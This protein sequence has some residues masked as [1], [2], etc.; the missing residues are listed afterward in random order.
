MGSGCTGVCA[1]V[2]VRAWSKGRGGGC[3]RGAGAAH[4]GAGKQRWVLTRPCRCGEQGPLAAAAGISKLKHEVVVIDVDGQG[5]AGFSLQPVG[6]LKPIVRV[7]GVQRRQ[8]RELDVCVRLQRGVIRHVGWANGREGCPA[9]ECGLPRQFP[10]PGDGQPAPSPPS[11]AAWQS[12]AGLAQN[13][14]CRGFIPPCPRRA[15][16]SAAARRTGIGVGRP[17]PSQA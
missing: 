13:A 6:P 17:R 5:V 16:A 7:Q 15:V 10:D 9:A 8:G 12:T 2:C 3:W 4:A 1:C 11:C 14:A